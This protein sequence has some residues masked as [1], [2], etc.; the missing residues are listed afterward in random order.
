MLLAVG[1]FLY[2]IYS[3]ANIKHNISNAALRCRPSFSI[4]LDRSDFW[5][6]AKQ[7]KQKWEINSNLITDFERDKYAFFF[8]P[9]P[10]FAMTSGIQ[11]FKKIFCFWVDHWKKEKQYQ[12]KLVSISL[13]LQNRKFHVLPHLLQG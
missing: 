4:L 10:H 5:H 6:I 7:I 8:F 3:K 1:I 9:Q 12:E 13:R 11:L 2:R